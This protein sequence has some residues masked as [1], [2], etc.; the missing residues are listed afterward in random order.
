MWC[1]FDFF[2]K[3]YIGQCTESLVVQQENIKL[4]KGCI[5]YERIKPD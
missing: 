2:Y 5:L 4:S 1:L 3:R